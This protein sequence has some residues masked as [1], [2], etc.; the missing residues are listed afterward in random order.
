MNRIG[1]QAHPVHIPPA[2]DVLLLS[3]A[4]RAEIQR[5]GAKSA[6]RGEPADANPLRQPRN[7]PHATGESAAKWLQRSTAWEQGHAAQSA[8][9]RRV[10]AT[11]SPREGDEH[12]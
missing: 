5:Q 2:P 6:A 8:T 9:R 4:E 7:K 12:R 1:A 11:P 3:G 10:Q